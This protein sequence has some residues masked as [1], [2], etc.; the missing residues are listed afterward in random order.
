MWVEISGRP[1]TR[2][3]EA[4]PARDHAEAM[5]VLLGTLL[6]TM[7]TVSFYMITAYT[8]TF[9]EREL[10]LT[11][12]DAL[13]GIPGSRFD[14]HGVPY[15]LTEEFVAVYRMHPLIPDDWNFFSLESGEHL[16][17]LVDVGV[18]LLLL[19]GLQL[20]HDHGSHYVSHHFQAEI[21]FLGIESSRD[22]DGFGITP[23]CRRYLEPLI[24]G[25]DYPPYEKGLP[26]YVRIRG[27]AVKRRLRTDY[28]L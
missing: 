25:E 14:D 28:R 16:E 18:D 22:P 11:R 19:A 7:T 21:R 8:P 17:P 3:T 4:V 13:I 1:E 6:V 26:A 10:K 20:R 15:S 9:G 5:S 23:A 27:K 12:A 2:R 24:T